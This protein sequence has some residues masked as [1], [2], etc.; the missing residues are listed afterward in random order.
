MMVLLVL[1]SAHK[2]TQTGFKVSQ[3]QGVTVLVRELIKQHFAR[4]ICM[5]PVS[6]EPK[7]TGYPCV[8]ELKYSFSKPAPTRTLLFLTTPR[9]PTIN[10]EKLL[11]FVLPDLAPK[12]SFQ[13]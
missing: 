4:F 13:H 10:V 2:V 7:L 9:S 6:P 5:A 1:G 12:A 8:A 3:T 11:I